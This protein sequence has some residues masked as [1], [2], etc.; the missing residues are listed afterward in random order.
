MCRADINATVNILAAEQ[1][2]L[3]EG[4][5]GHFAP[6]DAGLHRRLPLLNELDEPAQ[7][8]TD[9]FPHNPAVFG[10]E[11]ERGGKPFVLSKIRHPDPDG[12]AAFKLERAGLRDPA[13][14]A[15]VVLSLKTVQRPPRPLE[16]WAAPLAEQILLKRSKHSRGDG[17]GF[18][19]TDPIRKAGCILV[20][21][22]E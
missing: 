20:R 14:H 21:D 3:A 10:P 19:R 17:L 4:I 9:V 1:R 7:L 6:Y 2:R 16:P 18:V 15:L 11:L 8:A 13:Q 5:L 12:P 22:C